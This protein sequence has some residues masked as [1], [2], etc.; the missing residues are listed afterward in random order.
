VLVALA[1][2]C[3]RTE[4]L[5]PR[6]TTTTSTSSGGSSGALFTIVSSQPGTSSGGTFSFGTT[7]SGGSS[8][9]G[10]VQDRECPNYV[11]PDAAPGSSCPSNLPLLCSGTIQDPIACTSE[12]CPTGFTCDGTYCLLNGSGSPVQVTLSWDQPEDLDLHVVEPQLGGPEDGGCEIWYGNI[13]PR[14]G[15]DYQPGFADCAPLGWLD[16]DSN[17]ACTLDNID[18][19]N[20][21]YT[22]GVSPPQGMYVVRV[23]FWEDCTDIDGVPNFPIIPFAVQ[24][25]ANGVEFTACGQFTPPDADEGAEG[26]GVVMAAF[27]VPPPLNADGSCNCAALGCGNGLACDPRACACL[28]NPTP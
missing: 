14:P 8:G 5:E 17:A 26:S 7:T 11:K 16:R 23:D 22:P 2:G 3:G 9:S 19:E 12:G 4:P 15:T 20:V 1:I 27:A 24:I 10:T 28:P 21:L 18:I 25:R 13:G 6:A